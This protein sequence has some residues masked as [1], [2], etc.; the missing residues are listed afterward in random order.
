MRIAEN[1]QPHGLLA[2]ANPSILV[3]LACFVLARG[4]LA[5]KNFC[6]ALPNGV[7]RPVS[8]KRFVPNILCDQKSIWT[9][10]FRSIQGD[11]LVATSIVASMTAGL[12][13]LDPST[14]PYFRRTSTFHSFNQVLS[15]QNSALA[16][17]LFP[18]S[19]YG[20]SLLRKDKY[21][22]DTFLL[23]GESL[24]DSELLAIAMKDA[25]RRLQPV[26]IA[27]NGNFAD[28]WFKQK[29]SLQAGL[30]SGIGSFPSGHGIAAFSVA[31]IFAERYHS[32]RWVP[33]VAYGAAALIGFSRLT[34]SAHFPSDVFLGAA[35]GYSISKFT[36]LER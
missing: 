26:D 9:F 28:S 20:L 34:L 22:Q 24:L 29:G 30:V 10:P 13:L 17:E 3:L 16:I 33:Y 15:S 1:R 32:H 11:H 14:A 2:A 21:G 12:V 5:A 31:T 4:P 35:L 36:V 25:T 8:W 23:A 6:P 19:F 27:T 18:V 7:E